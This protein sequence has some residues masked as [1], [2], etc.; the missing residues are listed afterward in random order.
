[1]SQ[2]VQHISNLCWQ[3][4]SI[5]KLR[6]KPI[7][8]YLALAGNI[9]DINNKEYTCFIDNVCKDF[10]KVFL[11]PGPKEY[12]GSNLSATRRYL[13]NLASHNSNF[14]VLDNKKVDLDETHVIL[15]SILWPNTSMMSLMYDE[16]LSNIKD[17]IGNYLTSHKLKV[18]HLRCKDFIK[19]ELRMASNN[20]KKCIIVSHFSPTND[21][22]GEGKFYV[23][24][25]A[26]SNYNNDLIDIINSPITHWICGA[27]NTNSEVMVNGILISCN[28]KSGVF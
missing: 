19:N 22:N 20:G 5:S 24:K 12:E 23:P 16:Q 13:D 10:N 8:P 14:F 18:M 4:K 9:G 27:M 28:N 25:V 21:I 7:A 15:G 11:V 3:T 26:V 17:E 1:M 2:K 6:I